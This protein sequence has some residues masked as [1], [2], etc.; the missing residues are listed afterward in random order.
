LHSDIHCEFLLDK[1]LD[2][3]VTYSARAL[4][5]GENSWSF[6]RI[7]H[8]LPDADGKDRPH[9][10]ITT[11]SEIFALGSALYYMVTGHDVFPELGYGRGRAEIIEHL[12]ERKFPDT[13]ELPVLRSVI[14]KCWNLEYDYMADVIEGISIESR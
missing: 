12:R 2:L 1:N 9:M 6:Y 11:V 4:I 3:K 10:K 8:W 13:N 7:T 5:D 14:T